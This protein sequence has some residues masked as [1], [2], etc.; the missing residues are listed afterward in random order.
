V[1]EAGILAAGVGDVMIEEKVGYQGALC[2]AVVKNVCCCWYIW[3]GVVKK[4]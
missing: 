4:R 2:M 3:G 1:A